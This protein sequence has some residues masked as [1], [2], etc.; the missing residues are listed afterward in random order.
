MR[1]ATLRRQG[2]PPAHPASRGGQTPVQRSPP[3]RTSTGQSLGAAGA[4]VGASLVRHWGAKARGFVWAASRA[5]TAERCEARRRPVWR[6]ARDCGSCGYDSQ[7]RLHGP[8]ITYSGAELSLLQVGKASVHAAAA[9]VARNCAAHRVTP[10][11]PMEM[12]CS[13]ALSEAKLPLPAHGDAL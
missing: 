11:K 7:S 4:R 5:S 1:D 13:P 8:S 9:M 3:R 6:L 12:C 10:H 2:P